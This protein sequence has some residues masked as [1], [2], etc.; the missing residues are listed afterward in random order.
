MVYRTFCDTPHTI[1][2][3]S[4]C[5]CGAETRHQHTFKIGDSYPWVYGPMTTKCS[6]CEAFGSELLPP[7]G[8][9]WIVTIKGLNL[10][11]NEYLVNQKLRKHVLQEVAN[12]ES[13]KSFWDFF[14]HSD[15]KAADMAHADW[16]KQ[17]INFY[18]SRKA[19][20]LLTDVE[21]QFENMHNQ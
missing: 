9:L 4:K 7:L 18:N 21:K 17:D 11:G 16:I 6:G 8:T 1:S 3:V 12:I 15:K 19:Q 13:Q 5:H 14:Y 20:K 10:I 2:W